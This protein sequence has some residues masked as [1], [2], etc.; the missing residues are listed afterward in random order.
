MK[1]SVAV[2]LLASASTAMAFQ[3]TSS[4]FSTSRRITHRHVLA[5]DP[6]TGFVPVPPP[7]QDEKPKV[8]LDMT[9]IALSVRRIW[10]MFVVLK[11]TMLLVRCLAM[12][13]R[14]RANSFFASKM[15]T[16]TTTKHVTF[17]AIVG[18]QRSSLKVAK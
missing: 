16:T 8:E 1:L 10:T 7:P 17:F 9:G 3:T 13:S 18:T 15:T 5:I 2:S 11:D 14:S 4:A 6:T 12:F